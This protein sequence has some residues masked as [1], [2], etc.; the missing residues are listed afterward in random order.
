[1]SIRTNDQRQERFYKRIMEHYQLNSIDEAKA[2]YRM[3][4]SL[5]KLERTDKLELTRK[6]LAQ[7]EDNNKIL[8]D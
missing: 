2:L 4:T 7:L 5:R 6:V 8:P 3:A 1:M